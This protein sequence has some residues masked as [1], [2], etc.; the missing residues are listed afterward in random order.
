MPE[1]LDS[2]S[3]YVQHNGALVLSEGAMTAEK[4][5]ISSHVIKPARRWWNARQHLG[6][7]NIGGGGGGTTFFLLGSFFVSE[8]ITVL[9][10]SSLQHST[11]CAFQFTP[12]FLPCAAAPNKH[13]MH[14]NTFLTVYACFPR[15]LNACL[16]NVW[17]TII[18]SIELSLVFLPVKGM[19]KCFLQLLYSTSFMKQSSPCFP[20]GKG[21]YSPPEGSWIQKTQSNSQ[22]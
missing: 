22:I 10:Y 19:L 18:R 9:I 20:R 14:W 21:H 16:E 1:S 13:R 12:Q 3:D 4:S 2:P 17:L 11:G 5:Y 7:S 6:T 8:N 15:L